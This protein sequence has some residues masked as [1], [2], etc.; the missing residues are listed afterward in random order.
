MATAHII[1]VFPGIYDYQAGA[2]KCLAQGYSFI[3]KPR[4]TSAAWTQDSLITSQTLYHWDTRDPGS[5]QNDHGK[6]IGIK[7]LQI[8]LAG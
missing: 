3:K 4:R 1:H 2:L 7:G 5:D 8:L 6:Q